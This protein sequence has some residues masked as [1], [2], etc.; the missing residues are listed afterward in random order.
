MLK[1]NRTKPNDKE[2]RGGGV[3]GNGQ[4]REITKKKKNEKESNANELSHVNKRIPDAVKIG[5]SEYI[6]N[7]LY[8]VVFV[9]V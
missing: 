8:A 9:I 5:G 6:E 1:S 4:K 2:K 3:G 7:C